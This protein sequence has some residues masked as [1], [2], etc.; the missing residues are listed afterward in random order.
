MTIRFVQPWNGYEVGA[1]ATLESGE[2]DLISGGL[3]VAYVAPNVNVGLPNWLSD[4]AGRV[5]GL[6]RPDGSIEPRVI[7]IDE[8]R[9][10]QATDSG[11]V[12]EIVEDELEITVPAGLQAGFRCMLI[13]N[14]STT[15]TCA[16][17]VT[18]N[19]ASDDVTLA[20]ATSPVVWLIAGSVADTYFVG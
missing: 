17:G 12:V 13:P 10:I 1:I 18:I 4:S 2:S 14:A 3:A 9:E 6:A 7:A 8:A 19:G 5:V 20:A 15:L 16:E 11:N